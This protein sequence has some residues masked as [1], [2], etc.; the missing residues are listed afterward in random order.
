MRYVRFFVCTA[1]VA[2][3]VACNALV[4]NDPPKLRTAVV[5]DQ[6][7]SANDGGPQGIQ[8]S[9]DEKKCFGTCVPKFNSGFS[10][11]S[12]TSCD[13]CPQYAHAAPLC[14][15]GVCGAECKKGY[16]NCETTSPDCETDLSRT[17]TCGGCSTDCGDQ[18]CSP[19]GDSFKCTEDCAA[20]LQGC[21][22]TGNK[23]C[24]NLQESVS[25]CG[26]C[27][28]ACPEPEHSTATCQGG[29][30]GFTCDEGFHACNGHCV[31]VTDPTACGDKCL[32]CGKGG[33]QRSPVCNR[34]VCGLACDTGFDD[35]DGNPDNGCEAYLPSDNANCGG[36]FI[37]CN[38]YAG[39]G[40]GTAYTGPIIDPDP[41]T[42]CC[43]NS[44]CTP[45]IINTTQ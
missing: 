31:S 29:Q 3:T 10:C 26:Q 33:P 43:L 30:C 1:A 4:G 34:G 40:V 37:K 8:C 36:C 17:K 28:H 35:C 11:A 32:N 27:D 2:L 9:G 14:N 39:G 7:A 21:G 44:K 16:D 22:D 6:D 19:K 15:G 25:H 5:T 42:T 20:P 23:Q 41:K 18:F 45:C 13:P 12:E 24:V 38:S